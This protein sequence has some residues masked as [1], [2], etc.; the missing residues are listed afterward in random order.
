M[1][2]KHRVTEEPCEAKVSRTVLES[3]GSREG[4]ADFNSYDGR[5]GKRDGHW[6]YAP[7]GQKVNADWNAARNLAQ[8]DGFSCPLEL[9]VP[10]DG[11]K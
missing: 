1:C 5:L 6:F 10:R 2:D 11:D 3:G 9:H 8:W 7:S 4:V